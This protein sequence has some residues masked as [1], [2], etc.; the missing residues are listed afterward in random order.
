MSYDIPL[1]DERRDKAPAFQ[2]L[3]TTD[4]PGRCALSVR[5]QAGASALPRLFNLMSKLDIEPI[6]LHATKS[7]CGQSLRVAIDLGADHEAMARL[8]LR[9]KG[10]VTVLDVE[11]IPI[12]GREVRALSP[13]MRDG[14]HTAP[15]L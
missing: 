8:E 7:A 9:L 12:G 1:D 11:R 2:T 15:A 14:I 5:L 10:L 3:S 6:G 13:P 4:V